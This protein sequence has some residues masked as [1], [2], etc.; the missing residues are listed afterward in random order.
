PVSELKLGS[1]HV[2]R[3]RS[4]DWINATRILN[5]AGFGKTEENKLLR[6]EARKEVH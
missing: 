5:V 3:R 1:K 4:G 2:L 6:Y